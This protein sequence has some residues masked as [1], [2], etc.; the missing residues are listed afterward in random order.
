MMLV[1]FGCFD[2]EN[3]SKLEEGERGREGWCSGKRETST[4]ILHT[5]LHSNSLFLGLLEISLVW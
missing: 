1:R 2:G 4:T 5:H 3:K